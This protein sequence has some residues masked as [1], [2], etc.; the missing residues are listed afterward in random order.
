MSLIQLIQYPVSCHS[1]SCPRNA[2]SYAILIVHLLLGYGYQWHHK[3][4]ANFNTNIRP[5]PRFFAYATLYLE[6]M[7]VKNMWLCKDLIGDP[8]LDLNLTLPYSVRQ[9]CH[10]RN[11]SVQDTRIWLDV[12]R[13]LCSNHIYNEDISIPK[14]MGDNRVETIH[15]RI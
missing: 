8:E 6:C 4:Q 2:G 13:H 3:Q 12:A 11:A 5:V 10:R 15:R 7:W 1:I 14:S 9:L